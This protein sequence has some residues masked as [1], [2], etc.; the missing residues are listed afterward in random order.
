MSNYTFSCPNCRQ[1]IAA[2]V[3]QAGLKLQCSACKQTCGAPLP[4]ASNP[5]PL[6]PVHESVSGPSKV[7]QAVA[8]S[9]M[10]AMASPAVNELERQVLEGGRFVVFQYCISI[11]VMTFRRPSPVTF[12]RGNESGTSAALGYSA[13][14]L[15][16]GWWGIPWGPIFTV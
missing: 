14:S 8:S 1:S 11:L 2:R 3:E 7:P 4:Q 5:R 16:A 10:G 6:P 12:L 15:V 9:G 13:I